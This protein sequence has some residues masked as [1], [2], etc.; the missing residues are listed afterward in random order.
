MV[1]GRDKDG[2]RYTKTITDFKPY[3]YDDNKQIVYA[4]TSGEVSKMRENYPYTYEADIRYTQRFIINIIPIPIPKEN[5][6]ICYLDIENL[7]TLDIENTPQPIIIIGLYDSFLKKYISFVLL[8]KEMKDKTPIKNKDHSIYYF[9]TEKKLL[10]KFIKFIKDTD[11]D[12]ITGWNIDYDVTYI[13]NRAKKLNLRSEDM[14]PLKRVE[15]KKQQNKFSRSK[16]AGRVV[17]DL[18]THYEKF[19]YITTNKKPFYRLEY[20]AEEEGVGIKMERNFNEFEGMIKYNLNDVK[21]TKAIDEKVKIIEFWDSV[22]RVSGCTWETLTFLSMP[23]DALV[24]REARKRGIILPTRTKQIKESKYEGAFVTDVKSGLYKNVF[25]IDFA[26]LYPSLMC[27]FNISPDTLDKNGKI[28]LGNGISFSDK[29]EGIMPT[30]LQRLAK[31]RAEYKKQAKEK[32]G[33]DEYQTYYNLQFAAKVIRNAFYGVLGFEKYRLYNPEVAASVTWLA[34]EII[35]FS[36]DKCNQWGYNVVYGDT[37][38]LYIETEFDDIEKIKSYAEDIINKLNNTFDEFMKQ[39]GIQKNK[40][41]SLSFERIFDSI[42]F[43]TKKR[44]VGRT[45]WEDITLEKPKLYIKGFESRRSDYSKAG[46]PIMEQ[47]FNLLLDGK[48]KVEIDKFLEEKKKELIQTKDYEQIMIPKPLK[49]PISQY[50]NI[51]AHV[52]GIIY[53]NKYLGENIQPGDKVKMLY[54]EG[55]KGKPSTDVICYKDKPPDVLVNWK[56]MLELIIDNKRDH[57]YESLGWNVKE[58]SKSLDK[59][60]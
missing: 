49:K 47:I 33:T 57:I 22:R 24:L 10:E 44:Y 41:L 4:E 7:P 48:T 46:K 54:V 26:S 36:I 16:I 27:Q 12:I 52:R 30:I 25:S 31:L 21:V 8:K 5:M 45:V 59:W 15:G 60:F 11:P 50:K 20:I 40:F 51:G 32:R 14:S 56:K 53:A 9:R 2:K 23:I 17:F 37:D 13:I 1:F 29:E 3:F 39:F 55:V 43:A 35:K 28:R 6:R 38:S 42:F 18:K 34:R 58:E 19:C